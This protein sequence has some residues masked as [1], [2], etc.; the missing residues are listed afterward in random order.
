[1]RPG[2]VMSAGM[3]PALDWPGEATPG[4]FGPTTRVRL[5]C[6]T[7]YAHAAVVSCTG[8]PSVMTTASGICAST[9]SIIAALAKA[10]GTKMTD[11]SAPVSFIAS[12][13]PAKTG[14]VT[15]SKSICCP[16]LRGLVP[17]TMFVPARSIRRVCRDPSEPVTPWTMTRES[18][19]SQIAMSRPRQFGR[20]PGGAVHRV[21]AFDERVVRAVQDPP[22]L[23]GVVAVEP[24]HQ[25]L[26]HRFA[27]L[28]EQGERL[29]DAVGHRVAGGDAAEH[30][31]EHAPH[32]RV[33]QDDLQAVGHHLGAGAAADV[34]EVGRAYP[35]E[36]LAGVGHHVE[37]GPD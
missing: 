8:I 26:V 33:G 20:P 2:P 15:P 22:A 34:E 23:V 29:Q 12:A 6:P 1:M 37:R 28:A 4:Q 31:D 32:A 14:T 30:V 21:H 19:V 36:L 10:G 17:P 25:R 35:A 18:L 5:P 11:T 7:L 27:A 16:A 3:M 13:T 24:D 9:A